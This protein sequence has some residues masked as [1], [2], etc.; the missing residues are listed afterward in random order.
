MSASVPSRVGGWR[1]GA[2]YRM[3]EFC[4]SLQFGFHF[5]A[6]TLVEEALPLCDWFPGGTFPTRRG[7]RFI[8]SFNSL[9]FNVSI[10]SPNSL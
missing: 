2:G 4:L 3:V 5:Y 7:K 8:L 6:G 9:I 1:R 10:P